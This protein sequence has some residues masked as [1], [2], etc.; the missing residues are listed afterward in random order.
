V[1]RE[2]LEA[3]PFP[4]DAADVDAL[5]HAFDVMRA[6]R[7]QIL[8]A[9]VGPVVISEEDRALADALVAR[10]AVWTDALAR[11]KASVGA[12]RM[13]TKQLRRYAPT[14]ARDL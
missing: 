13:G 10:D 7:Q 12:S 14:D 2:L 8:D 5:L 1:I 11:A 4:P 9:M 3:T 6:A